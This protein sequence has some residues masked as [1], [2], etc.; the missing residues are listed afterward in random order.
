M[1]AVGFTY[2]EAVAYIEELPKFTK[3]H[4]LDHVREFLRRLGNPSSDRK[5]VHVAGTNGK[6]SVCAYLQAILMAEGKHT[7]FFTSPHLV[8]INERIRMDNIQIDNEAFLEAFNQVQETARKME[9]EELGHPSYF[10]FLLGMGMTAFAGSDVEYIIL[11]TGIGGRLDATNYI[12][13]PALAVITSISLDHT[14]ILGDS[15]EEIAAEKAGIIKPGVPVFFDASN[16]KACAVIRKTAEKMLAPCRE[17]SKN[18]YEILE[19]TSKDI[20]FSITNAYY[21]NSIWKLDTKALYQVE[22]AMLALEAM[23]Y[24]IKEEKHLNRWTDAFYKTHWEGRMEEILPGVILDGAHNPG[25][26]EAFAESVNTQRGNNFEKIILFSAVKEKEYETMIHMLC[27]SVDAKQYKLTQI[28]NERGVSTKEL[29]DVFQ[30]YTDK[31][32]IEEENLEKAF[33]MA[34]E[35]KGE[36]GRVYCLGSLYLIGMLKE[37]IAGG[38][39]HA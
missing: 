16:Q 33:Y 21:E 35:E 29:A 2:D 39:K 11:E 36:H 31:K 24:L 38:K 10:E 26:I 34:L 4:T 27:E 13:H 7:G 8:S 32:I 3:K 37:L 20:A 12:E 23:Q 30:K 6:G 5:I 19:I 14:D 25:A 22:N 9:E 1:T 18:A 17:I 15:I 28:Q